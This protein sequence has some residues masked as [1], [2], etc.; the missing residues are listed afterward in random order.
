VSNSKQEVAFNKVAAPGG[1]LAKAYE[2]CRRIALGHYENFPVGS[3]LLPKHVRPDFFALYAFM[4]TADDLADLPSRTTEQKLDALAEWRKGLHRTFVADVL[5]DELPLTFLALRHTASKHGLTQLPFERL[6]DAFEFDARGDVRF[7][8]FED[9]MWYC[10]RSANPV[11]QL[12]LSLL[13]YRDDERV[14]LSNNICS[15]LQLLNFCQDIKEDV[16]N[17]RCYFAREELENLGINDISKLK[18]AAEASKAVLMQMGHVRRLLHAGAP[19]TE[20]VGGRL[21][22]ELRGV[23]HGAEAL[24]RK[25]EN[26]GGNSYHDRPKLSK[27]EHLAVLLKS[28]LMRPRP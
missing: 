22:Y 15:G 13:G 24:L 17:N 8:R 14:A 19:L 18:E 21:K 6:L 7:E 10:D 25:L 20:M 4:R 23:I 5:D 16:E 12:V 1:R 3:I 11:G 2:E 28:L 27:I 9:L 26:S